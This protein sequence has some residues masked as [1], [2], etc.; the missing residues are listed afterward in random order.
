MSAGL[1][2]GL[3]D[4]I[5]I[6]LGQYVKNKDREIRIWITII[7]AVALAGLMFGLMFGLFAGLIFGLLA[8]ILA[9]VIAV[10]EPIST[11]EVL[12]IKRPQVRT[13]MV[14]FCQG[15]LVATLGCLIIALF[16]QDFGGMFGVE[17]FVESEFES[18]I[19]QPQVDI[20]EKPSA[21]LVYG[22]ILGLLAS[23]TTFI[24]P[25]EIE[26][27]SQPNQGVRSSVKNAFRTLIA[28]TIILSGVGLLLGILFFKNIA[29]IGFF[30]FAYVCLPPVFFYY[31]GTTFTKHISLRLI[32][33]ANH[34]LPLKLVPFLDAMSE[35]IILRKVGGGYIFIHR[36]L[37]EYFAGLEDADL[38]E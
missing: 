10:Y 20:F 15:V 31:G 12:R 13:W 1:L 16:G 36:Y 24:Q 14:K 29:A 21:W 2:V 18:R 7:Y 6:I 28:F 33:T 34:I 9:A 11:I 5:V 38:N 23:L 27:R 19:V 32:L 25:Q 8:G 35:R 17:L 22:L 26:K 30:T 37:L 3:V 4:R